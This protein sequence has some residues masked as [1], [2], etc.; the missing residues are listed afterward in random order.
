MSGTLQ[1]CECCH[2]EVMAKV[3][4][5]T[6]EVR[7]RRNREH[8]AKRWTLGELVNLLDPEGTTYVRR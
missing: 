2:R 4:D 1:H 5:G 3:Q 6:L 8:H 7:D